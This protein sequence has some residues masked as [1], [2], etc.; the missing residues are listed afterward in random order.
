MSRG[1]TPLE[2]RALESLK[3]SCP[4]LDPHITLI[5]GDYLVTGLD[6]QKNIRIRAESNLLARAQRIYRQAYAK[7]ERS[8]LLS[9]QG[10][11]S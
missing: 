4:L 9:D 2:T 10:V 3:L 6:A 8:N 11:R 7:L 5:D 1:M